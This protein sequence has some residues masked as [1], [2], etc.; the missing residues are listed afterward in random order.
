MCNTDAVLKLNHFLAPQKKRTL[1]QVYPIE[2]ADKKRFVTEEKLIS[3]KK[4][5]GKI[6]YPYKS[7]ALYD[8]M[9]PDVYRVNLV[10]NPSFYGGASQPVAHRNTGV[11]DL[12]DSD[13]RNW[14]EQTDSSLQDINGEDSSYLTNALHAPSKSGLDRRNKFSINSKLEYI[15]QFNRPISKRQLLGRTTK[16]DVKFLNLPEY[17]NS[18]QYAE[19]RSEHQEKIN[20]D[21]KQL[22]R[23]KRAFEKQQSMLGEGA[24]KDQYGKSLKDIL[25]AIDDKD[26]DVMNDVM[27]SLEVSGKEYDVFDEIMPLG[28]QADALPDGSP[29]SFDWKTYFEKPSSYG[30]QSITSAQ[31]QRILNPHLGS[32]NSGQMSINPANVSYHPFT[33]TPQKPQN[34]N[35]LF[36]QSTMDPS[37]PLKATSLVD[38]LQNLVASSTALTPSNILSNA[39]IPANIISLENVQTGRTTTLSKINNA[40]FTQRNDFGDYLLDR[41]SDLGLAT[42]F[43]NVLSR[44]NQDLINSSATDAASLID[45]F[46]A[47]SSVYMNPIEEHLKAVTDRQIDPS[48]AYQLNNKFT[49]EQMLRMQQQVAFPHIMNAIENMFQKFIVDSVA[50]SGAGKALMP[51][52]IQSG[53][54]PIPA[55][56]ANPVSDAANTFGGTQGTTSST[57]NINASSFLPAGTNTTSIQPDPLKSGKSVDGSITKMV[58]DQQTLESFKFKSLQDINKNR[59]DFER[60]YLMAEG[61]GKVSRDT[62][63]KFKTLYKKQG[64]GPKDIQ[65]FQTLKESLFKDLQFT[66]PNTKSTGRPL[67][68]QS[69]ITPE[70]F[71]QLFKKG[72]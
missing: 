19:F 5:N 65:E 58:L 53:F 15:N 1:N 37:S 24:F 70:R 30:D 46:R 3:E 35:S 4:L 43:E 40:L 22:V 49:N 52:A 66:Q 2:S 44:L 38:Q 33:G 68:N 25:T 7:A 71:A 8:I 47:T 51:S 42:V 23:T 39:A 67:F 55:Y 60:Y 16:G 12:E 29:T 36:S 21:F 18:S 32:S 13:F 6:N 34:L 27:Q 64:H 17:P 26:T 69:N 62:K 48:L 50:T 31:S 10:G 59:A 28:G 9:P 57:A 63:K 11:L 45:Q 54:T 56:S 41:D 72:K 20:E 61:E 14:K